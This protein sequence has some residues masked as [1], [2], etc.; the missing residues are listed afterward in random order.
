MFEW[1]LDSFSEVCVYL[2]SLSWCYQVE[3]WEAFGL[4]L[5]SMNESS[6]LA[7]SR[8]TKILIE[9]RDARKDVFHIACQLAS[10]GFFLGLLSTVLFHLLLR[11]TRDETSSALLWKWFC[12]PHKTLWFFFPRCL[13]YTSQSLDFRDRT[14]TQTDRGCLPVSFSKM[15]H[16]PLLLLFLVLFNRVKRWTFTCFKL[17]M[18]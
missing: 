6:Y 15:I 3:Q 12:S 1:E 2:S 5:R 9:I 7:A 17:Q 10:S 4:Y 13:V 16:A 11:I 18:F 14:C 8:A